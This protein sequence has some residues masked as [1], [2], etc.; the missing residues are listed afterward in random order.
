MKKLLLKVL[1]LSVAVLCQVPTLRAQSKITG[2]V[3]DASDQPMI[4]VTVTVKGDTRGTTTSVDG[5]YSIAAKPGEVLVFSFIGYTNAEEKVGSRTRIDVKLA[6]AAEQIGAVEV[7]SMGYGTS[8][9][10]D[11]TGSVAKVDMNEAMKANITNF[12]QALT[13]RLAGV[14]VRWG[15]GQ[16]GQEANITIR[17][18]NSLTQSNSPLFVIDGFQSESSQALALSSADIE[19]SQVLRDASATAIYGARGANGVIVITTKSGRTGRPRVNFSASYTVDQLANKMELMGPYEFVKLQAEMKPDNMETSYF[20]DGRDLEWYRGR[21]GYDWQDEVYRT[22]FTQN[23]SISLTGGSPK[24]TPNASLYNISFSALDQDGIMLKSNFQR[25]Q[26][27]VNFTQEIGKRVKFNI[28]VNY[29][30]TATGGLTPTSANNASSQSGWLIYS[31]WGY[32]PISN[33]IDGSDLIDDMIDSDAAGGN[34]YRFNPVYSTKN[35]HKKTYMDVVQGNSYL[36]FNL[37]KGLDL[38]ISGGYTLNKRRREAFNNTLT[39]TG[40]PGSPSGKGINGGIYWTDTE[41]WISEA[42]LSY[43]GDKKHFGLHHLKTL[44]GTT[45]QGSKY[46]YDGIEA[47]QMTTEKLSLQALYTGTLQPVTSDYYNWRQL[48]FFGRAEYDYDHRYY[49]NFTLRADGSS[50]FPSDNRWGY[51]PAVGLSWNFSQENWLRDSQV[52]TNGKLRFSWGLTGNN[53]T[54]S[55]YDYYA[56]LSTSPTGANSMDYVFDGQIAPGYYV[57]SMANRRLKWETTE[58]YN[59]GFDFGFFNDRIRLTTDFY[60]KETRDL[61]LSATMP[62][63]SGYTAAMMNI[64]SLSNK[65]MEFTLETTN[66]KTQKFQWTSSFNIAFNRNRILALA[67]GQRN[68]LRSVTWDMKY[69]SDY[70]YISQIGSSTGMMYGLIYEGTYKYEDF[71]GSNGNYNLKE[72][73]PYHTSVNRNSIRPGDPKYAD[74]NGD[75]VVNENDRTII[76]R[77]QPI[78]TGGFSNTFTYG[79]FDLN[80][81]MT[82]SYG[83]DILNANRLV[84]ESGITANTNQQASYINRWSPENPTSNIPRSG[85]NA[86]SFYS[87]RVVE[88]GSFL[89]LNSISLGYQLPEKIVRRLHLGSVRIHVSANNICTFTGYSGPDPEVSTRSS[90]LTP[91][92]DWSAYPRAF[93]LTAGVDI[94]F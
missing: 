26:G 87:S 6:E 34:D 52:L 50:R 84:F 61:L 1:M 86:M 38:K 10:R 42:T 64:G 27:R 56:R 60:Y 14:V 63:S 5:E 25:Y 51:F 82:W 83:N 49:L 20:S 71:D 3:T 46:T 55:P 76:G 58:Q 35:E 18:N 73:I 40:Y 30:R 70:P 36:N 57:S 17:G 80:I 16:V 32:R 79:N 2:K 13:G 24:D 72:G 12:D 48:S 44:V 37:A 39:Y 66:I 23:Y 11:L 9:K 47:T 43:T 8:L 62:A 78:H 81:F 59:L 53:R 28:N 54:S 33:K 89:R 77:G 31:V 21:K 85:A 68:L 65:G 69:N 88:D 4:G 41:T 29:T 19:S 90:V 67:D 75:G 93:G 94:S 45:L 22:A 7:V 91:G 92:F 74:I 15:D